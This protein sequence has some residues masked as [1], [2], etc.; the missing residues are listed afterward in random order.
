[1]Q[2]NRSSAGGGKWRRVYKQNEC[3]AHRYAASGSADGYRYAGNE[4]Y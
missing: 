3:I 2:R 4:W 1:M